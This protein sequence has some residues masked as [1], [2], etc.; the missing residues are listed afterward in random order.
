MT[1]GFRFRIVRNE[2]ID[3]LEL[4]PGYGAGLVLVGVV[5]EIEYVKASKVNSRKGERDVLT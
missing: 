2:W 4:D 3:Y 1:Y 5:L